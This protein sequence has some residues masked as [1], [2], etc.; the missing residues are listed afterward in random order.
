MAY[1]ERVVK[2]LERIGLDGK[3]EYPLSPDTLDLLNFSHVTAVPYENLDILAG[4]DLS[5][6]IDALYEKIVTNKRGGFCF[7]LNGLFCYLLRELGFVCE[8]YFAR[9]LRE[10]KEI[11]MRRHRIIAVSLGKNRYICD[12]G[13]G[14]VMP[15]YSLILEEDTVQEQCGES[16][17]F[18]KDGSLGWILQEIYHGEWRNVYSFYEEKQYDVDFLQPC[19]FCEKH[20]D[21]PFNKAEIVA[22][23]TSNGRKTL[24]GNIYKEFDFDKLV[25]I[26]ENIT[27]ERKKDI[28]LNKFG[29]KI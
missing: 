2:Y 9:F 13:V 7:E 24:D 3:R 5:L 4:K 27:E 16:Y 29:I 8:E 22:I 11:P 12:V 1:S 14:A 17:R 10:E 26:E 19:F 23:K 28:L 6:E 21:S 18:I 15:R 25:Y 20:K